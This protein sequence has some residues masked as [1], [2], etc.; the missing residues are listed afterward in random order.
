[1]SLKLY[2]QRK[3][4]SEMIS[5]VQKLSDDLGAIKICTCESH[6][7]NAIKDQIKHLQSQMYYQNKQWYLTKD[8]LIGHGVTEHKTCRNITSVG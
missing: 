6:D 2:P 4:A 1:M 3:L 5:S 7:Y 8:K